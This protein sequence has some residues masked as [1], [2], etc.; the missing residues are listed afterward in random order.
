MEDFNFKIGKSMKNS[1]DISPFKIIHDL[2]ACW[3]NE[4]FFVSTIYHHVK[5]Y[6][7]LIWER[8]ADT[9]NKILLTII[10]PSGENSYLA[11]MNLNFLITSILEALSSY[12]IY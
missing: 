9:M 11:F 2:E 12:L 1:I 4:L 8:D 7:E 10:V 3:P 6:F 5:T